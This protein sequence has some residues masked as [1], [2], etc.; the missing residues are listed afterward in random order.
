MSPFV[1]AL[2][3]SSAFMHAG[4]NLLARYQRCETILFSRFL[5]IVAVVGFVPGIVSEILTRS[6]TVK[7]WI[8][9]TGSGFFCGLYYFS[10]ARAYASSDFT[11]V[12]PVVRSLPV[13]L[14]AFGDVV[15]GR[16][17]TTIGWVGMWLVV[18]GCFLAP[19]HSFRDI[20]VRSYFNRAS[21]WMFIAAMG[22]VG[23]TLLDKIAA[24]TVN[25]GPATAARYGYIFFLISWIT[26]LVFL[27][28]A[29][30]KEN[31]SGDVGWKLPFIAGCLNFGGYWLILWSYQ[32]TQRAS[33]I[34]ALR[35]FSIVIGV[36]LAFIIYKE[37]GLIVRLTGAF[38]LTC[39]LVLIALGGN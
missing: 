19:L 38:L 37:K 13:L 21:L 6:L 3:L 27:K 12:Y 2:V 39:G 28:M 29:K 30:P 31:K 36:I 7:A 26:Y 20:A 4:W 32:L 22:T 23:F 11:V 8:C 35:Q 24:E 15:R 16:Y 18:C 5:F 14:V 33:Y 34:I 9:V 10:L 25:Q 1:I 17:P